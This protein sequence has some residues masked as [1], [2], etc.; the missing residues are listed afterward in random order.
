MSEV[1][2]CDS[3]IAAYADADVL[4]PVPLLVELT[5]LEPLESLPAAAAS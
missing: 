1:E 4:L 2:A 3:I 5:A